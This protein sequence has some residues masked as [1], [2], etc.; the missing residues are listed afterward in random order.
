[1]LNRAEYTDSTPQE[2]LQAVR[3]YRVACVNA[4]VDTQ[5]AQDDLREAMQAEEEARKAA[6]DADQAL[7]AARWDAWAAK[8]PEDND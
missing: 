4:R 1:M 6:E 3:S 2:W 5:A 8:A 7:A